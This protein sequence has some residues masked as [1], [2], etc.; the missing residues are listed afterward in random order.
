MYSDIDRSETTI[1][2]EINGTS[3]SAVADRMGYASLDRRQA[4]PSKSSSHSA[5]L[6]DRRCPSDWS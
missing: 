4:F 6:I 3:V 1:S 5:V 2:I